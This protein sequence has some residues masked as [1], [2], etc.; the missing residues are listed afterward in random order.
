MDP[1]VC[2]L[3]FCGRELDLLGEGKTNSMLPT[4]RRARDHCR[5]WER[6]YGCDQILARNS[7]ASNR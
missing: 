4:C 2:A 7:G 5:S 6:G 3:D 1:A